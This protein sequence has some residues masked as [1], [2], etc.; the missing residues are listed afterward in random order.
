LRAAIHGPPSHASSGAGPD[1]ASPPRRLKAPLRGKV[2]LTFNS[3]HSV[4]VASQSMMRGH[5]WPTVARVVR[6]R[7]GRRFAAAAPQVAAARNRGGSVHREPARPSA[8]GLS[9]DSPVLRG[10]APRWDA[11]PAR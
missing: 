4:V 1:D 9:Q 2:I 8:A 11:I 10:I 5:P 6:R 3:M 7:S